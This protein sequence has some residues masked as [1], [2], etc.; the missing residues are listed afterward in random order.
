MA[1]CA[2]SAHCMTAS[3][4]SPRSSTV[5]NMNR[6]WVFSVYCVEFVVS[7]DLHYIISFYHFLSNFVSQLFR[8]KVLLNVSIVTLVLS[9]SK[10]IKEYHPKKLLSLDE[11]LQIRREVIKPTSEG[12]TIEEDVTSAE[13]EAMAPPGLDDLP[14]GEDPPPPVETVQQIPRPLDVKVPPGVA[15]EKVETKKDDEKFVS[16]PFHIC[17]K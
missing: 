10:L 11:F 14:P 6:M 16:I 8:K 15:K 7:N 2:M 1:T 5:I 4:R 9:F 12:H 13:I 3:S 17:E